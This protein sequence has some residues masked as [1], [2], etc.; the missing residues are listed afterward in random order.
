MANP[1]L[2]KNHVHDGDD[3]E[4]SARAAGYPTRCVCGGLI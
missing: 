4:C 1:L 2:L 3:Q